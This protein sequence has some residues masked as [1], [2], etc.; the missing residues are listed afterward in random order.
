MH[1][2]KNKWSI[3]FVQTFLNNSEEFLVVLAALI[4]IISKE[5]GQIFT[6]LSAVFQKNLTR[7]TI[8]LVVGSQIIK[9]GF[10]LKGSVVYVIGFLDRCHGLPHKNVSVFDPLL[11]HANFG[12]DLLALV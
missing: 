4:V 1:Q 8:G 3:A 12:L 2:I 10:L 9:T 6:D 11:C 5:L 7:L